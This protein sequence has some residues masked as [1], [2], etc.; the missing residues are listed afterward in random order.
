MLQNVLE[1]LD[2]HTNDEQRIAYTRK[3]DWKQAWPITDGRP[4]AVLAGLDY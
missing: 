1:L 4:T 2:I 3:I